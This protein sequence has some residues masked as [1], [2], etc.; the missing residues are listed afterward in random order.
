MKKGRRQMVEEM[1]R[2]EENHVYS[3]RAE[4]VSWVVRE[5]E[6]EEAQV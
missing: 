2:A 4:H 6:S 3:R 1:R 5:T